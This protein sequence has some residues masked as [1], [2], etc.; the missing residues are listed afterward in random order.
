V[1]EAFPASVSGAAALEVA[2]I[3]QEALANVRRHAGARRATVTLGTAGAEAWV[4]IEDDGGGFDPGEETQGMGFTGMRERAA[5]L[6]GE[7]EVESGG[8]AGTRV[9][10][11]VALPALVGEGPEYSNT[12][13]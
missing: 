11:R 2:R 3:V 13:K 10:L 7:L 1:D 6:G 4:E 8:G 9:R 5:A 12:R